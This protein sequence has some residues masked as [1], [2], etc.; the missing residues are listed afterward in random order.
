MTHN[1]PIAGLAKDSQIH[2]QMP[3][4]LN[5][6]QSDWQRAASDSDEAWAGQMA[7]SARDAGWSVSKAGEV[8]CPLHRGGQPWTHGG[9]RL[10]T[11]IA[12]NCAG[13]SF[14]LYLVALGMDLFKIGNS[15]PVHVT[16][17]GGLVVSTLF[18]YS[19]RQAEMRDD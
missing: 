12:R 9:M 2:C 3:G 10:R 4:C 13:V 17:L 1:D 5:H 18:W 14:A 11:R 8:L 7:N 15:G 19:F 6:Y 16:A